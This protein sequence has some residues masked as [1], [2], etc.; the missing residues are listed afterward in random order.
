M[1]GSEPFFGLPWS[2]CFPNILVPKEL[3]V[4]LNGVLAASPDGLDVPYVLLPLLSVIILTIFLFC[5][6]NYL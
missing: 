5:S 2:R 3:W 6:H 4:R 1:I